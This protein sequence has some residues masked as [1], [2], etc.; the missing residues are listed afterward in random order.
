[1]SEP[2]NP[3]SQPFG[4]G[5]PATAANFLAALREAWDN[6]VTAWQVVTGAGSPGGGARGAVEALQGAASRFAD[7][8]PAVAEAGM[9]AAASTLRYWRALAEIHMRY[10]ASLVQAVTDRATGQAIAPPAECRIVADELRAFLR[11]IGDA[12]MQEARR[13]QSELEVVGESVA[14]T[15]EQAGPAPPQNGHR[16]RHRVKE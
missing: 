13:L 4:P 10:Q 6:G 3:F 14:R 2:G 12:A 9:I 11:E 1:M 5:Q 15:A 16:R 8:S 7:M